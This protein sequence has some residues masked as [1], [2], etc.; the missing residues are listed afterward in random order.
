MVITA[1][2][3]FSRREL[4]DFFQNL[5]PGGLRKLL[6]DPAFYAVAD[7][8]VIVV[9]LC[10]SVWQ[11]TRRWFNQTPGVLVNLNTGRTF[12]QAKSDMPTTL[13]RAT[14]YLFTRGPSFYFWRFFSSLACRR[15]F[16]RVRILP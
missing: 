13:E 11:F 2:L 15:S 10:E 5:R 8:L 6:P 1:L 7:Y 3:Y 12:T 16:P 14:G 9:W 4:I